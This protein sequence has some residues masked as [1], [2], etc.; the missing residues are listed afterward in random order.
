MLIPLEV[1]QVYG[2]S[3]DEAALDITPVFSNINLT[4]VVRQSG[5]QPLVLQRMHPVFG[6]DVHVDIEAVT[7]HLQAR[8]LDTPELVRTRAGAL[9][10]LE[11]SLPVARVWRALSFVEGLTLQQSE[12][13]DV[14]RSAAQLLGRFHAALVDLQHSFVHQRPLHD[15]ERH[16]ANLSSALD[17][18]GGRQDAEAQQL[19]TAI[20]QQARLI[21]LDYRALPRRII[22]GD[23]K[24]SNILF[25]ATAP[26]RARCMID[27]DTLGR[28]YLAYELGDALRSWCNP[29]GEEAEAA[30][31]EPEVFRAV[32]E[33]YSETC[34][35]DISA[36]ELLSALDGFETV[37]LELASRYAADSVQDHYFGW[38]AA[39]FASRRQHNL[40]R[41]RGQLA[42]SRSVRAQRADLA[43]IAQ[44][45]LARRARRAPGQG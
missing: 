8:K 32:I 38:D 21:R 22:H 12:D 15:T 42:L 31:V 16:L 1:R 11:N 17:S 29:A 4:F 10:T 40:A 30:R 41:A 5:R 37:S 18:D 3:E 44:G 45:T 2:L 35:A 43:E 13:A 19:G 26:P 24:L 36:E 14:L 27:L 20:L 25:Y 34:P 7:A 33:G 6:P 9:W 23:P 28:G 39:R